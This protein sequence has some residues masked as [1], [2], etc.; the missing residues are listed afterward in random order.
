MATTIAA[1]TV[2]LSCLSLSCSLHVH[3]LEFVPAR[4][5][6]CAENGN[7]AY[8]KCYCGK[9]FSD[10]NAEREIS[11][12]SVI[13]TRRA[14]VL[15]VYGYDE[16]THCTKCAVCGF[17]NTSNSVSH[18]LK[19]AADDNEHYLHCYCGYET[20]REQHTPDAEGEGLCSVCR[21]RRPKYELS[22]DGTYYICSGASQAFKDAVTEIIIPDEYNGLPV[23]EIGERAFDSC[24]LV[25]KV[26][27]GKN[28]ITV[29]S[30]AF[31]DCEKLVEVNLNDSLLEIQYKAFYS[32]A[33][34]ENITLP[35]GLINLG[36]GV[37]QD[38]TALKSVNVP[39][40]IST[41]GSQMFYGCTALE[42]F[43]IPV[44]VTSVE[45]AAFGESGLVDFTV[46]A[47]LT[48]IPQTL[49]NKCNNL[50]T[51]TVS[52]SVKSIGAG[53]FMN[54]PSLE[55]VYYE[56]NF[57]DWQQI[58]FGNVWNEKSTFNLVCADKTVKYSNG[59]LIE[60]ES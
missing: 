25:E 37:F 38:C 14:H 7:S 24:L 32:C 48:A 52:G 36:N 34:L 26:T 23:K 59:T 29:G 56:K 43:D 2:F 9:Y 50:K 54:C 22:A 40:Q 6:T 19:Y 58:S 44:H 3:G 15:S 42:N 20:A 4:E 16:S 27:L 60:N 13:L 10:G 5:A 12:D 46:P 30:F 1:G 51:V 31:K 33:S 45:T 8:Y 55:T 21:F 39:P 47:W 35:Q 41:I 17:M 57:S 18:V 53:A 11:A 28:V 49:F